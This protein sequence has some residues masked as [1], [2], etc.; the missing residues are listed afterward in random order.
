MSALLPSTRS[1]AG[2]DR[3]TDP[4]PPTAAAGR[5]RHHLLALSVIVAAIIPVAGTQA[6]WSADEGAMLYQAVAVAEGRGW[7]F[8]HPFPAA[9]PTGAW[10]PLHLASFA[11]DGRYVVLGKHTF[12]VRLIG[13]L[14]ALGG[15]GA[16]IAF[17]AACLVVAAAAAAVL[18]RRLERRAAVPA[19]WLTGIASPLFPGAYVAWAHTLA[20]ALIGWALVGLTTTGERMAPRRLL[21]AEAAGAAAL[22]AACLIRT[23]AALAAGAIIVALT[24]PWLVG[25]RRRSGPSRPR[26]RPAL[27]AVVG[28]TV[29]FGVDRVTSVE[30]TGAVV[31]PGDRWGGLVGRLEGFA[32]TWLRPDFSTAPEHLLFLVSATAVL[33]AGVLA[34][35]RAIDAPPVAVLIG[36]AVAAVLVRF[37]V[38][39]TALIPG[40]VVAFPVLFAGLLLLRRV[41]LERGPAP[42][43]G[44]FVAIDW[45]AVLA[46]QYRYGGGGEWGGRYFALALPAAVAL[47]TPALLRATDGL[48]GRSRRLGTTAAAILLVLPVAMGILGLRNSREGTRIITERV[49]AEL[50][51]PGDGGT[52]VVV[53][54]IDPLGR[55]AWADLDRSRWLLVQ[56]DADLDDLGARLAGL[57]IERFTFVTD[58][59]EH[60]LVPLSP[61]YAPI[62]ALPDVP[63]GRLERVVIP[64]RLIQP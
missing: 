1:S 43:L 63:A 30:Q 53:T 46:T 37:L 27:L 64:V 36:L 3:P 56:D 45:L 40:L 26:L 22:G 35:R 2:P 9:D 52:P 61:W 7:T 57:G 60:Q 42:I 39:P 6:V 24:T 20:A 17:S 51:A 10:Y 29:G 55:W 58:D 31:A 54:T 18:A 44:A 33:A 62:E 34:R 47:A 28:T 4:V 11:A 12:V 19:L 38:S 8:G 5:L 41:D 15:Y 16:V 59:A 13:T 23:E 48:A 50:V 32:H 21:V 49:D 25:L 14:H